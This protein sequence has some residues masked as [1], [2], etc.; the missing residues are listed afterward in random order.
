MKKIIFLFIIFSTTI[1]FSQKSKLDEGI[2]LGI[3]GGL[4]V[5][6]LMG[7]VEDLDLGI[8]TSVHIGMLAEIIVSDKFSIQPE[9]LYSGQGATVGSNP[10]FLRKKLNYITLPVMAKFPVLKGLYLETGPQVGFLISAKDKTNDSNDKI[11]G[12]KTIDFGLNAGLNYEFKNGVF[13]QGR[14]NLGLTDTGATGDANKRAS[15]SVIQ[16][17]LGCLF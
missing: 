5:S 2:K 12:I 14:Y 7:D 9:L 4:N 16:F 13:I 15:N 6:N 8:R 11:K 3:K 17:S 10:G 1:V